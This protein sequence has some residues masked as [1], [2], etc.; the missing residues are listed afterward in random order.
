MNSHIDSKF[1]ISGVAIVISLIWALVSFFHMNK[2]QKRGFTNDCDVSIKAYNVVMYIQFVILSIHAL[3]MM[4][5]VKSRRLS[6][7]RDNMVLLLGAGIFQG[8]LSICLNGI[9]W[10]TLYKLQTCKEMKDGPKSAYKLNSAIY[11][12]KIINIIVLLLV[13]FFLLGMMLV[14]KKM[15]KNQY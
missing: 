13:V 1:F 5:N 15:D 2:L 12:M 14:F 7:N 3:R 10:S 9:Q 8:I 4:F 6:D 11:L